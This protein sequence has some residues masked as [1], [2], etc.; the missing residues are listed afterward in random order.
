VA[1]PGPEARPA[2]GRGLQGG[3]WGVDA[4]IGFYQWVVK[5][6]GGKEKEEESRDTTTVTKKKKKKSSLI[7]SF[8][9]FSRVAV[10]EKNREMSI[11]NIPPLLCKGRKERK[12]R[13]GEKS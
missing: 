7:H 9:F 12:K 3:E 5:R 2:R 10:Y 11:T 13:K 6:G 8:T 4:L 1:G